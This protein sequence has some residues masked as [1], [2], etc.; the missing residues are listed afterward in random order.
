MP[1]HLDEATLS[2]L[3]FNLQV[4][5]CMRKRPSLELKI[6]PHGVTLTAS[7]EASQGQLCEAG[8]TLMGRQSTA[9]DVALDR[10][11]FLE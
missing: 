6:A 5:G 4:S 11:G 2:L 7:D 1:T 3:T 9:Y 10:Q 8:Y